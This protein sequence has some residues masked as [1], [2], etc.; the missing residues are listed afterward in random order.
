[1]CVNNLFCEP[2]QRTAK[3]HKTVYKMIK[4]I[5]DI[6]VQLSDAERKDLSMYTIK[7]YQEKGS[8]GSSIAI[9]EITFIIRLQNN[10]MMILQVLKQ[11]YSFLCIMS[12]VRVTL[13]QKKCIL[14]FPKTELKMLSKADFIFFKRK[15]WITID[16]NSGK[17][18][19]CSVG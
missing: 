16:K 4:L 15:N 7:E 8:T 1:M 14:F 3:K 2:I 5:P 13:L 6:N 11:L 19:L 12:S 9:T 17:E 18:C 10:N